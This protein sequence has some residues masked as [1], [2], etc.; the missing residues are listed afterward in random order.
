MAL[1]HPPIRLVAGDSWL[2]DGALADRD[3][4]PLDVS[5]AAME[6][7]LIDSAGTCVAASPGLA[8]LALWDGVTITLGEGVT[9]D[10]P[11]GRYTDALRITIASGARTTNVVRQWCVGTA[12]SIPT[13]QRQRQSSRAGR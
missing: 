2:I 6:W 10:L 9:E 3:G 8:E 4:S 11:A 7:T 1:W 12:A 13:N 5:D